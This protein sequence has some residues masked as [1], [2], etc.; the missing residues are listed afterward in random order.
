MSAP[1]RT[2]TRSTVPP[3]DVWMDDGRTFRFS[4]PFVIGR[5][6]ACDVQVDNGRVSRRHVLVAFENGQ[7]TLHDQQSGN[8]V[9]V[10]GHRVQTA[11]IVR[12]LSVRLGAEGPIVRMEV[13]S[14]TVDAGAPVLR[15]DR[16]VPA[17]KS[18]GVAGSRT[19]MFRV[20]LKKQRRIYHVIVAV[21]AVA[22]LCAG[23]DAYYGHRQ[24]LQQQALAQEIFYT[25][26]EMDVGLADL[27]RRVDASG[28]A[29]LSD[30]ARKYAERRRTLERQYEEFVATSGLYDHT[31]TPRE[32]LILRVTRALGECDV[33]APPDYLQEVD[34]YIKRWQR[35]KRFPM[36]VNRAQTLGY[37]KTIVD[38]FT[39][40]DLPPQFFYLAMQESDFNADAIGPPTRFG[41]AK[42]MWM[43]LAETGQRYGLAAGPL[44]A[45]AR[46]DP[47]DDRHNWE[48][49]TRAAAAYIK[50]IYAT[51][52][53]ASGL[54]VM[55]SYNWGEQRV[56]RLLRTMPANPRERNWWKVLEKHREKVPPE[57]YDYV[58]N[59]VAAAVIGEN[60]G[61]FG[62]RFDNPLAAAGAP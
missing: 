25:M 8:G 38:E 61:M 17:E 52:A 33:A 59:I 35:T 47:A 34:L 48:K 12:S 16:N 13:A 60:P 44:K 7:W 53:Q 49:S 46:K 21:L 27:E 2:E 39:K 41:Y 20:A 28:S 22:A 57:T 32:Q 19:M 43:F 42:G 23:G 50:E 26:K 11:P 45:V 31:L 29:Q 14:P 62:F 56:L 40:A 15:T 1:R 9:I 6:H 37:T 54:L 24:M 36:A 58:F 10:D 5:D 51:D 3:L 55:A 30:Q 4:R 18:D